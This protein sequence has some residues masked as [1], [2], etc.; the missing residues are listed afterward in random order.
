MSGQEVTYLGFGNL[1]N[2]IHRK[3]MKK[4]FE[5]TIMVCGQSGLGKSTMVQCLFQSGVKLERKPLAVHQLLD[6][7]TKIEKTT[8]EIEEGGVKIKLTGVPWLCI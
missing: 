2:H 1:P 8:A 5:L 3:Y 4:G 7:T 6:T